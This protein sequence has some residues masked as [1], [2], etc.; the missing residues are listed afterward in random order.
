MYFLDPH[1][2]QKR[3]DVVSRQTRNFVRSTGQTMWSTGQDL[4]HRLRGAASSTASKVQDYAPSF[5]KQDSGELIRRI[6]D[7]ASQYVTDANQVQFMADA[8][9]TVTVTGTLPTHQV[10]ELLSLLHR[11]QGVTNVIN[12]IEIRDAATGSSQN[13][14]TGS[15]SM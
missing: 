9:G 12:R 2:G 15:L 10:H 11:V 4:A 1:R 8:D 6:R 7:E 3:R 5:M 13:Q 14:A